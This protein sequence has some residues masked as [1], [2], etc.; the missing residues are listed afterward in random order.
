MKTRQPQSTSLDDRIAASFEPGAISSDVATLISEV[1]LAAAAA[2]EAAD[3]VRQLALDPSLTAAEANVARTQMDD[4]TF[5]RDRMQ[6]AVAKLTERKDQLRREEVNRRRWA[7][8]E[9]AEEERDRLSIELKELYPTF[10]TRLADVLARIEANDR[11]LERING[12]ELPDNAAT[13]RSA[14]MIARG[15]KTLVDGT[16]DIPRITKHLKLP[17]FEYDRQA[18]FTWPRELKPLPF[19]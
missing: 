5:R 4:A 3:A 2:G 9:K 10:S 17:A 1:E 8:Y 7:A 19:R 12:R 11:E 16:S 13:L 14:E 15:L 6:T 18:R